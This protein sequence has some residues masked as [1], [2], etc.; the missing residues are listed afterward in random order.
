MIVFLGVMSIGSLL[1]SVQG[2]VSENAVDRLFIYQCVMARVK[3]N[4]SSVELGY[5][6]DISCSLIKSFEQN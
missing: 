6:L 5:K 1:Q 3:K 2:E 4:Q